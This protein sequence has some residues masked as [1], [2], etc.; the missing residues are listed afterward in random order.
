VCLCGTLQV[1]DIALFPPTLVVYWNNSHCLPFA[2]TFVNNFGARIQ[3]F[4]FL[5]LSAKWLPSSMFTMYV[6]GNEKKEGG[7]II[8][9][10]AGHHVMLMNACGTKMNR[11]EVIC[12]TN[13]D[14]LYEFYGFTVLRMIII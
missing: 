11:S 1:A 14:V 5:W 2:R 4:L 10:F 9:F 6:Q 8:L 7:T 12:K 13:C 3:V